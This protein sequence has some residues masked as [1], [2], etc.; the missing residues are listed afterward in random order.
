MSNSNSVFNKL[1][2]RL[3]SLTDEE[4]FSGGSSDEYV[5]SAEESDANYDIELPSKERFINE[6]TSR[7]P[8]THRRLHR[9]LT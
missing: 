1:S 2:R 4:P 7:V 5:S 6:M 9:K 8:L 3:L